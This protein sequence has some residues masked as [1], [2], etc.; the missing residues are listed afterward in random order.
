MRY[1]HFHRK[2]RYVDSNSDP[3]FTKTRAEWIPTIAFCSWSTEWLV[4]FVP[5]ISRISSPT[6]SE[7][8][9]KRTQVQTR[10][11]NRSQNTAGKKLWFVAHDTID[12]V[13]KK[14]QHRVGSIRPQETGIFYWWPSGSYEDQPWLQD[15]EWRIKV[16]DL[17]NVL[18]LECPWSLG[19]LI[20][21][22]HTQ[23]NQKV[24]NLALWSH[25]QAWCF[26]AVKLKPPNTTK[27]SS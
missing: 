26:S 6:W 2:M 18:E 12:C 9:I 24:K 5:L 15:S 23:R 13:K 19:L 20:T 10:A 4:T 3:Q 25:Q 14:K 8:T 17:Q 16:P 21:A 11:V 1:K 22:I 27:W 7:P